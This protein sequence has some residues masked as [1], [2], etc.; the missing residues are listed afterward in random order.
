MGREE[1][2]P[3]ER[4]GNP[5]GFWRE[6]EGEEGQREREPE[7]SIMNIRFRTIFSFCDTVTILN[8]RS[9][10]VEKKKNPANECRGSLDR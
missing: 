3:E 5:Q 1:D 9:I 7:L 6:L 8:H 2:P 10:N 4:T